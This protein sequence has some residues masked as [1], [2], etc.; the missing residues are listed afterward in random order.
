M[1]KA[2][3]V[4]LALVVIAPAAAD[5][6]K[7]KWG[8]GRPITLPPLA[9]P[10]LVYL[11]LDEAALTAQSTA[12]FRI[13][14]GGRT[15]V[16]YR[17]VLENGE[18]LSEQVGHK[19]VDWTEAAEPSRMKITLDLGAAA[20]P[21]TGLRFQWTGG[22]FRAKV[23]V[24]E[25]AAAN[26]TAPMP[27]RAI[28]ARGRGNLAG[29]G[30]STGGQSLGPL[31]I[32]DQVYERGAGFS[33]SA[34]DFRPSSQR[35]LRINLER[36]EG[37]L[38]RVDA[39]QTLREL[40]LPLSLIPVP[41]RMTRTED[42][43]HRRTILAFDPGKLTR[44]LAQI[45]FAVKDPLFRRD[46]TIE[47]APTSPLPGEKPVYSDRSYAQLSRETRGAPTTVAVVAPVTVAG[48][49]P[50]TVAVVAPSARYL[51]IF[52]ENRDDRPLTISS[53]KLL[54]VRRGLVFQASPGSQYALWYERRAAPEPQY[55]LAKLP[56]TVPLRKLP[57]AALGPAKRLALAPPPPPPWSETHPAVFWLA[58][59]GVVA[60]L[61]LIILS[62]LRRPTAE[63]GHLD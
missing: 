12:E 46:A 54:R 14:Q 47:I 10:G 4:A 9:A 40:K 45:S 21:V 13:V 2:I 1:R 42:Y 62:A 6:P 55:D 49:A 11:P 25:T 50:T 17:T 18:M 60:L 27:S 51:R 41:A 59:T 32:R 26:L 63:T 44:D 29:R 28:P 36:S 20:P 57:L 16:P 31:L 37:K 48:A 56:L 7:G 43:R 30:Q 61:A 23:T 38:P 22:N 39:I 58:L 52:I 3:A 53:A 8:V 15:E 35:Y 33:K 19:V 5:L 24:E 34:V